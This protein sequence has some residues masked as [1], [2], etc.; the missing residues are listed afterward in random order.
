[1]CGLTGFL[2]LSRAAGSE[3]L[4]ET[5]MRM[6]NT[7]HHRGPDDYGSWVDPQT[8]IALGFRRLSIIDLSPE[9]HQPMRSVT[10]R[11]VAA[12]NGEI[13]NHA[14]LRKELESRAAGIAF[15]GHSD[16]EV[17]LA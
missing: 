9:G 15:R 14:D 11:Y 7:L 5:V 10:G 2:N 6:A 1:M 3:M 12:F 4:R 8:G 17:M 16:T 13:Y